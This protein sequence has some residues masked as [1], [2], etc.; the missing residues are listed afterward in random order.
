MPTGFNT[1]NFIP[2]DYVAQA[3]ADLQVAVRA[4][5]S[6]SVVGVRAD[7]G[8]GGVFNASLDFAT[9]QPKSNGAEV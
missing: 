1:T 2:G 7:A 3:L 8:L 6:L 5:P 4:N 9:T